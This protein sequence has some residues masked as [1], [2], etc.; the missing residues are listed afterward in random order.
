VKAHARDIAI[1]LERE[2]FSGPYSGGE[3]CLVRAS[4]REGLFERVEILFVGLQHEALL[5]CVALSV[6]QYVK[7]QYRI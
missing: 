7:A 2:G 6:V 3:L 5:L 4:E 1:R